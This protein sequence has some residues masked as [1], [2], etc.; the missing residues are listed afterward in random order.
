[1]NAYRQKIKIDCGIMADNLDDHLKLISKQNIVKQKN[2]EK[3]QW[4]KKK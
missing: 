4:L 1:M 2:R 3:K